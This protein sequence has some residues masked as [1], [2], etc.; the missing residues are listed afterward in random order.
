MYK[1]EK[2]E[3]EPKIIVEELMEGQMYSID[4]YVNGAGKLFYTPIIEIKTGK[5]AG[6]DDLFMYTQITPSII[7][8]ENEKKAQLVVEK[9]THAIGLRS[10][11]VH[12]ELMKTS[13]GWK[14]IELAPRTGGFREELL[15]NSFG[16][17]HNLND[18]LIHLGYKPEIKKIKKKHTVFIKFWP[19]KAGKLKAIKG[20]IKAKELKSLV[21]FRQG[22]KIGDFAGLSKNGHTF[23]VGF[24]L[25]TKNRSDLLGDIRKLEKWIKIETL[26]KKNG[27]VKTK[28]SKLGKK[29]IKTTPIKPFLKK[30]KK[31][32]T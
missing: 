18:L 8:R 1:K 2:N 25:T 28:K 30:K 22:K 29:K 21:K 4:G 26:A 32:S 19:R 10:C 14:V 9:A 3:T 6:Y 11:S 24:T 7:D 12:C 17:K 16:I 31:K 5:D 15:E 23:V 13:T 20:L 27:K